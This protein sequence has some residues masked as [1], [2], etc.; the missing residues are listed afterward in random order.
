MHRR[1][2][3]GFSREY[4]PNFVVLILVII[5]ILIIML[6]NVVSAGE[7]L[8]TNVSYITL[9]IAVPITLHSIH[10][11]SYYRTSYIQTYPFY[12]NIIPTYLHSKR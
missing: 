3:P 2:V 11:S 6:H 4:Y 1:V 7:A 5:I 9:A 8:M 12:L 10:L